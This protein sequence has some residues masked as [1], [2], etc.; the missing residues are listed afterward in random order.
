MTLEALGNLGDLIGGVG[1][2]ITLIYL[3]IQI[4]QNTIEVR[5]ATVQ[6]IFEQSTLMYGNELTMKC[7]EIDLRLRQGEGISESEWIILRLGIR[8]SLL[9]Y[10][11]VYLQYL[12]GRITQE[13]MDAYEQQLKIHFKNHFDRPDWKEFWAFVRRTHTNRFAQYVDDIAR[14]GRIQD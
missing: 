7:S 6:R 9:F 4:R 3:A 2:I 10:E 5:N 13:V 11:Q 1:V 12:E 14:D 8:R